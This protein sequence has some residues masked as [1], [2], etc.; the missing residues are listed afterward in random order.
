MRPFHCINV[1][2][3]RRSEEGEGKSPPRVKIDPHWCDREGRNNRDKDG[4]WA[5]GTPPIFYL[6]LTTNIIL[7]GT[8]NNVLTHRRLSLPSLPSRRWDCQQ[9]PM[10]RLATWGG[11][12]QDKAWACPSSRKV[13]FFIVHLCIILILSILQQNLPHLPTNS[14]PPNPTNCKIGHSHSILALSGHRHRLSM[15]PQPPKSNIYTCFQGLMASSCHC[16]PDYTRLL[17]TCQTHWNTK[18]VEGSTW[19]TSGCH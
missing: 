14:Q 5:S 19:G 18:N 3:F 17:T 6:F 16:A 12:R 2:L 4:G 7:T 1:A 10:G 9:D 15:S 13:R 8:G 11:P